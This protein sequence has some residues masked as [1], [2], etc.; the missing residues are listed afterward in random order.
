MVQPLVVFGDAA[1]AESAVAAGQPGDAAFDHRSML[2]VNMFELWCF[3]LST[4]GKEHGVVLVQGE[5]P[6][7]F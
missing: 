2:S 7:P 4:R 3:G 5:F 1:V 6:T